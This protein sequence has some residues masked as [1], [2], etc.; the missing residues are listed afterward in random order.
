M[1]SEGSDSQDTLTK[2]QM[3][4]A[5]QR[6]VGGREVASEGPAEAARL[7][8][9]RNRGTALPSA[10][11][12]HP[13]SPRPPSSGREGVNLPASQRECG[14][15]NT[16]S[17]ASLL[18]EQPLESE[19]AGSTGSKLQAL[20]EAGA[21]ART[22]GARSFLGDSV[23]TVPASPGPV[24]GHLSASGPDPPRWRPPMLPTPAEKNKLSQG[25]HLYC[26]LLAG[27]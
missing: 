16:H 2:I 7:R 4:S 3:L 25:N 21:G 12:G 5:A 17:P 24:L 20:A 15:I 8:W 9:G 13:L 18:P 27:W 22:P 6:L 23:G 14:A 10:P 19:G 1:P 26:P 11:C